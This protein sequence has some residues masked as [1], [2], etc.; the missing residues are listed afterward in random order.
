MKTKPAKY[1]I[2][3]MKAKTLAF[4]SDSL[5]SINFERVFGAVRNSVNEILSK[6][7]EL[8]SSSKM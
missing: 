1:K 6:S 4:L 3:F 7:I 5:E 2:D 8:F